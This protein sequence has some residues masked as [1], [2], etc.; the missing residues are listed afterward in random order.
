MRYPSRLALPFKPTR[1]EFALVIGLVLSTVEASAADADWPEYLGGPE[2]NHYSTLT[3]ITPANV[4]QLKV[5]WEYRTGDPGE[6]Q[7]NPLVVAGVL[8]GMTAAG[9]IFALD[10][11]TGREVW[12][13]TERNDP[14]ASRALSGNRILRGLTYWAEGADKRILFTAG[15]WLCALDATNGQRIT[16]FGE[17][18]RTSLKQGLG[19]TAANKY[20]IA[21]TPGTVFGDLLIVPSRVSEAADAA[22]GHVRAFNIRTGAL[23]WTFRT[24]PQPGEFGY[25]TWPK[26]TWRNTEVGG[27]N[28]WAGMSIDRARGIV[29]VPTGSAAPDF[30]GGA[31]TGANLFAN[32]LLALDAKTGKRLWHYQFVHHDIWDRDL[33]APPNLITTVRDGRRIDAVAQIT[34]SGHVFVFDRAT[35]VPLFPIDEVTVPKSTLPGEAAWPTQPLPRKP[36]PFARQTLTEADIGPLAENREALL[37]RFRGARMGTFEPFGLQETVLLPGYD[38]G[39]EWGGAAVDPDG[40]LYVNATEMAYIAKLS[41]APL[42]AALAALSPGQRAYAT[43]CLVCHGPERKGNPAANVPSMAELATRRTREEVSQLIANGKGMMPGFPALAA[44]DKQAL[45]EFLFGAEK[46]EES[47]RLTAL[48]STALAPPQPYRFGGY[49]RWTDSQGYPAISPP[50][51]SLTAIDL[52]T[53]EQRWRVVLGEFKELTAKGIAPTGAENYGGPTITAGGLLFIAATKDGMFRAFDRKTGQKLWETELP[54]PGF[55][56]PTTYAIGGKQFVV[57]AAGGTK[58]GTKRGESYIAFALP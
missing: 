46:Q 7:H 31:R 34:K 33:P 4:A 45:I 25:E 50:W 15:P 43:L 52:N 30:W 58:L 5:A 26:E 49:T 14:P 36:T 10:G 53:G 12:R 48:P 38:G 11:A 27:A 37:T 32:C 29:F 44:A 3:Q 51:G 57:V 16:T 19:D 24:I 22:L 35:G 6:M 41:E 55:A 40:V 20:V 9:D 47:A 8:Y 1:R 21:T 28:S 2:R 54:A 39:G 13:Y 56:T 23:E 18:G 17:G 42:P